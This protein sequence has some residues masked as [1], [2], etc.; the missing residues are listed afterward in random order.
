MASADSNRAYYPPLNW[1][2]PREPSH[3]LELW[4]GH[5]PLSTGIALSCKIAILRGSHG[6]RVK[7]LYSILECIMQTALE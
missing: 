2:K 7:L 5:H 6:I 1:D 4:E 3:R